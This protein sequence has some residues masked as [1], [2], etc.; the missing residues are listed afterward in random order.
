[1]EK[2]TMAQ[3]S[4]IPD[5]FLVHPT[6]KD[7]VLKKNETSVRQSI[8][9]LVNLAFS[10]KPFHPEK[11]LNLRGILFEPLDPI[12]VSS[13]RR[14]LSTMLEQ[15]EPRVSI[16]DVMFGEFEDSGAIV[17]TVIFRLLNSSD[18]TKIDLYFDR[19]R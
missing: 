11:V 17:V 3:Y 7:L 8:R 16:V 6:T 4:D 5:E 18:T 15:L 19:I 13:V 12:L 1:V 9:N 10:D 14:N 2:A